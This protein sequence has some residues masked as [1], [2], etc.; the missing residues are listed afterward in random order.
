MPIYRLNEHPVFPPPH[1]A[2]DGLLAVGGDLSPERLLSAYRHGIFPWYSDDE[3]ILWWSPDPRAV[4]FPAELH[5]S[6][7]LDRTL[8]SGRYRVTADTAFDEVIA[9]CAQIPRRHERGTWI[10]DEMRAAYARLHA[11]GHAHSVECWEGDLLVGGLYGVAVGACFCGES[12]FA[13]RNDASKTAL[14][15]LARH[16]PALGIA[17]I[18]CQLPNPHLLRLGAREIPRAEYLKRLAE[19]QQRPAPPAPWHLG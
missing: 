7:S 14:A 2:E 5:V 6:R 16:C 3:P 9:A 13:R 10:T 19:A 15:T 11:L 18:D 4:I 12:M 8:R 1:L 17:L